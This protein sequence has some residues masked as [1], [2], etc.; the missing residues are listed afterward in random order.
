MGHTQQE[1]DAYQCAAFVPRD[2]VTLFEALTPSPKGLTL[3][4]KT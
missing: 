1:C 4:P 3:S 2:R